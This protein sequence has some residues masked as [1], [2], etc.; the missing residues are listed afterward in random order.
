MRVRGLIHALNR[1]GVRNILCTYHH[2]RDIEGIET[3]RTRTIKK[4]TRLE[5]GPS[6]YK[7]LADIYL[8]LKVC[9]VIWKYNPDIIHGHLH[10]GSL[11]GWMARWVFFWRKLPLVFDVQGSLV[12]E[13]DAHGYFDKSRLLRRIFWSA[14]WLITRMPTHFV[15]SSNQSLNILKQEFSISDKKLTLVSDGADMMEP[16]SQQQ[17][18]LK[19]KLQLPE[20]KPLVIYTGALLEA[21]GLGDLCSLI[22]DA[23]RDQINCHFLIV[24][25]PVETLQAFITEK[26]LQSSCTMAG[27]VAYEEL[28]VYL[29]QAQVAVEPKAA[30]S[31][32][33]SGK[34]LNYMAAGLPV[35][36]YDTPNNREMLS[37]GGFYADKNNADR[38]ML[39]C[40]RQALERPE[41]ALDRGKLA[42]TRLKEKFSWDVSAE[43]VYNIYQRIH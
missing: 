24:G 13:L 25:Y 14:E 26:G 28:P 8:F 39:N 6:P 3:V 18:D 32:E 33:A 9:G 27:R 29:I 5:A 19:E 22:E 20:N 43:N 36:C 40:L 4:Y 12:G 17:A 11:I 15:C 1:I 7:Y 16:T 10:E 42:K 35:V 34:L 2:G 23:V 31:G 37:E 38:S 30:D 21:K 41:Q